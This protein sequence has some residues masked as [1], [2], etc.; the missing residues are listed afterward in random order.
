PG[1]WNEQKYRY[2]FSQPVMIDAHNGYL[3]FAAEEGLPALM[4]LLILLG[5][6]WYRFRAELRAGCDGLTVGIGCALVIWPFTELSN[7]GINKAPVAAFVMLLIAALYATRDAQRRE[8][9]TCS[10]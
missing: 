2:G 1:Q 5:M 8:E 6:V 7:A 3:H 4:L 10:R 9:V